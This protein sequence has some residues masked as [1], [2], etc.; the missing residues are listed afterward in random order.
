MNKEYI[1]FKKIFEDLKNKGK[2]CSP[3][4][5][6]VLE[7]ENYMYELPPYVR[8]CNF[9]ARKLS[10]SYIKKEFLWYLNG[11][12]YDTSI[13]EHA[14][15]WKDLVNKDGSINSNYGQYIFSNEILITNF[16]R[17]IKTLLF[18]K[19]SRRA[20]IIILQNKHLNSNTK[21][22][23]CT[24]AINFRIRDNKLNMSVR[25]RSQDAIFGMG[26]DLPCFSFIHEMIYI[27]LKDIKYKDLELGNYNHCSDSFHIYE[28]H[29]NMLENILKEKEEDFIIEKIPKINN[30]IE[31]INLINREESEEYKFLN[32]L[33]NN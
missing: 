18:D 25:M 31:V 19:D 14:K 9:K 12:K 8:L 16:D 11:D 17:C 20:T 2:L 7:I 32:W 15:M 28:R 30:Y 4:G 1:I 10:I 21:D 29:F 33:K 3:R 22:F 24:Y 13:T 5:E 23:P 26:N 6:K 27:Y